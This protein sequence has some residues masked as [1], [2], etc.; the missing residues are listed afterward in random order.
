MPSVVFPLFNKLTKRVHQACFIC[1]AMLLKGA[2]YIWNGNASFLINAPM[3]P[4]SV[5]VLNL[6]PW[7]PGFGVT[8]FEHTRE[9][10]VRRQVNGVWLVTVRGIPLPGIWMT[11]NT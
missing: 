11:L 7:H 3:R 6:D 9:Y 4:S 5:P 10:L 8:I 1:L 2:L